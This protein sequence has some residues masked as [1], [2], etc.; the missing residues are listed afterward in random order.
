LNVTIVGFSSHIRKK[1]SDTIR[2]IIKNEFSEKSIK[3]DLYFSGQIA[4]YGETN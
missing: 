2:K 1:T 3:I 4:N